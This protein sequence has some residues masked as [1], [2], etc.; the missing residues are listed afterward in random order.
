[1]K[2]IL[3]TLLF[4]FALFL[5]ACS[6]SQPSTPTPESTPTPAREE[7]PVFPGSEE[8]D[9]DVYHYTISDTDA[10]AVQRFYKKEMQNAG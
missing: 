3:T 1:M 9:A 4:I 2:Q 6:V 7:L 10:L 5:T 8:I